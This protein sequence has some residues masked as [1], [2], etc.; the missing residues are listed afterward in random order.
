MSTEDR[1]VYATMDIKQKKA[2]LYNLLIQHPRFKKALTKIRHCHESKEISNE[3]LCMFVTGQ[4]GCGKSKIFET[5]INKYS[6]TLY[7]QTGTKKNILSAKIPSPVRISTFTEALLDKLGDPYPTSGKL[8]NKI[9]RL[10]KLIIK[11]EVEL[12]MLDEFQHFVKTEKPKDMYHVADNFKSLINET[13]VSVVLF[14]LDEAEKI[15]SENKQLGRRFTIKEVIFPFNYNDQASI[16]EFRALLSQI[17]R[18]LPFVELAGLGTAELADK[19]MIATNGV[20]N[21]IMKLIKD[22]ALNALIQDKE[23][24]DMADLAMSYDLHSFF[25]SGLVEKKAN[26]FI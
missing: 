14:G 20:M 16:N 3:P 12:I 25:L 1:Q 4:S 8:G 2:H 11:C 7:G 6:K 24:I 9:H 15:F 19:I 22:A 23:K 10:Q 26:P 18:K 13:G 17:D 21:S 5:Y